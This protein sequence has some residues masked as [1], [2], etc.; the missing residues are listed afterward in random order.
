MGNTLHWH[1]FLCIR[2]GNRHKQVDIHL[3]VKNKSVPSI[4]FTIMFILTFFVKL[5]RHSV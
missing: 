4:F 2:D 3:A 5:L 1:K